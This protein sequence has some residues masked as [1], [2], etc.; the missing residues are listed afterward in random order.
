ME[1]LLTYFIP[2]S[3]S[4]PPEKITKPDVLTFSGGIEIDRRMK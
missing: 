2:Q 1:C 3:L 4:I